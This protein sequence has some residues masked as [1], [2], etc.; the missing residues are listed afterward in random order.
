MKRVVGLIL[1]ALGVMMLVLA[2]M[3]KWYVLP[4]A[5]KT[6]LDQY[7]EATA[8]VNFKQLLDPAKVAAGDK[9][10]YFRD[11]EA[12]QYIY[13]RGDVAA[14]EQ[15][16]AKEQDLTIFDYFMRVN[17]NDN[18]DL[19]T[20]SSARYPFNRVNSELADCCG[21]SVNDEPVNMVGSIAPVKWPFYMEQK[22]Y[23]IFNSTLLGPQTFKFEREEEMFGVPTWVF[24]SEVPPTEVASLEVPA[25]SLPGAKKNAEGNAE[26]AEMYSSKSTYW[27]EPVTGQIVKGESSEYTTYDLNG[28]PKLVKADYVG[29]SGDEESAKEIASL[30]GL[31]KTI[32]T[33]APLVLLVLGLAL[34]GIA[35]ALL[36][37][38]KGGDDS[39]SDAAPEPVAADSND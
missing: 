9:D 14:A 16:D 20:A 10:P 17:R 24:Y 11:V 33:T 38:G 21:A 29:V 25:A 7:T 28:E 8:D 6:P 23:E 4:N 22:D 18:G 5:A 34:I 12:T 30:A 27:M 32:G 19:V 3:L 37:G 13:V 36:R 26:L 1:L 2:P 35:A 15:P 31:V 39:A